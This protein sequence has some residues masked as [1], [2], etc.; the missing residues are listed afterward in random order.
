MPT[1]AELASARR[2]H[3]E[4]IA[5]LVE[6][7]EKERVIWERDRKHLTF[8]LNTTKSRRSVV[9]SEAREG[10]RQ[11]AHNLQKTREFCARIAA[12]LAQAQE[13]AGV[14]NHTCLL[15]DAALRAHCA[16]P[17]APPR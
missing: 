6:K 7:H 14:R 16:M 12:K 15:H 2:Q 5:E 9:E 13:A 4:E 1:A 17:D 8:L 3:A 11:C 10:L